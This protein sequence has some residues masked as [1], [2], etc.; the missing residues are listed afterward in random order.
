MVQDDPDMQQYGPEYLSWAFILVAP[1]LCLHS[2][3]TLSLLCLCFN[4]VLLLLYLCFAFALPLHS[5]WGASLSYVRRKN[6]NRD[7]QVKLRA[8][9]RAS[10]NVCVLACMHPCVHAGMLSCVRACMHASVRACVRAYVRTCVRACDAWF[11]APWFGPQH[12]AK[13]AQD[14]PKMPQKGPKRAPR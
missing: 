9:A 4:F 7:F 2:A 14:S 5:E 11:R 6:R 1:W 8:G 12:G 10:A 3:F 13:M